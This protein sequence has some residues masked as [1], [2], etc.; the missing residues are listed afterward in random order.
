MPFGWHAPFPCGFGG[1]DGERTEA[2]YA[3]LRAG[4]PPLLRQGNDEAEIEDEAVARLIG[5]HWDMVEAYRERADPRAYGPELVTRME[6][7]LGLDPLGSIQERREAVAARLTRPVGEPFAPL[8][9][10]LQKLLGGWTVVVLRPDYQDVIDAGLHSWPAA[11]PPTYPGVVGEWRSRIAS[12]NVRLSPPP[13]AT[14]SE[15]AQKR[16]VARLE[17]DTL[18][19]AWVSFVVQ[20]DNT[21]FVLDEEDLDTGTF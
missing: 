3:D 1:G 8:E 13:T 4:R 19:P 5:A 15:I 11:N 18:L 16:D 21:G 2:V 14:A 7:F 6:R 20:V 9:D 12:L 17:L 10:R